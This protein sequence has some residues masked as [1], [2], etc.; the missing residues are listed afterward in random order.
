MRTVEPLSQ[1]EL[2]PTSSFDELVHILPPIIPR[3]DIEKLLGGIISRGHLA[4]LDCIGQG[5]P[6]INIGKHVGYLR[7]PFIEW[8]KTRGQKHPAKRSKGHALD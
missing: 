7:T 5:P 8:L 3:K 2:A 1:K 4:N 6:R